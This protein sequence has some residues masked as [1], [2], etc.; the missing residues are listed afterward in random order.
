MV[1][2]LSPICLEIDTVYVFLFINALKLNAFLKIISSFSLCVNLKWGDMAL[3]KL[4][5]T[6]CARYSK[7]GYNF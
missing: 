7:K 5:I 6:V 3:I 2:F 1:G 4:Q